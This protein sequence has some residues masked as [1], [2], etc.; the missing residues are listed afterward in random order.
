MWFNATDIVSVVSNFIILEPRTVDK[1]SFSTRGATV[2]HQ[3]RTVRL[4]DLA[5][6][7]A[8]I[9]TLSIPDSRQEAS[10]DRHHG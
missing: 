8:H 5:S 10:I 2:R 4:P 6:C 7:H 3:H 1:T 9:L